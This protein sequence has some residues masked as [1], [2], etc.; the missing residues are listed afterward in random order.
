MNRRPDLPTVDDVQAAIDHLIETTGKPPTTLALAGHLGLPNTTFRR[1][2]PDLTTR[3][4]RQRTRSEQE[5]LSGANRFEQLVQENQVLK[6]TNQDLAEHLE[7]AAANIQRLTTENH[8]LRQ[9][10]ESASSIARIDTRRPT[11]TSAR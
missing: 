11:S 3:L 7:L 8:Q 5:T 6:A 9:A 4:Q 2:F 10:I 1:N